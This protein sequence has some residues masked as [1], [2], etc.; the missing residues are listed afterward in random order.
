MKTAPLSSP[1]LLLWRSVF[2]ST[3]ARGW[4]PVWALGPSSLALGLPQ[5]YHAREVEGTALLQKH[6][7]KWGTTADTAPAQPLAPRSLQ[8]PFPPAQTGPRWFGTRKTPGG[9]VPKPG[10][11]TAHSQINKHSQ[12]SR[13]Q[14]R[15][16]ESRAG[17]PFASMLRQSWRR[18]RA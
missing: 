2:C 15:C 8:D 11:A 4:T 18:M 9:D 14:C 3:H 17:L 6:R 10:K 12:G 16:S 5:C 1:N 13:L 7:G